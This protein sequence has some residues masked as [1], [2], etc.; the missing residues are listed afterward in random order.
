MGLIKDEPHSGSEVCV[1][2]LDDGTEE[3]NMELGNGN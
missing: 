3:G 1:T 2:T